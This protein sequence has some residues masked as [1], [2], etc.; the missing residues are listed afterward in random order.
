MRRRRGLEG[1]LDD[2]GGVDGYSDGGDV[3]GVEK[4]YVHGEI[5]MELGDHIGEYELG[6]YLGRGGF[7]TVYEARCLKTNRHVALKLLDKSKILKDNDL[8]QRTRREIEL[9]SGLSHPNIVEL[10][11]HFED[12]SYVYMVLELAEMGSIQQ[13]LSS[14]RHQQHNPQQW[15]TEYES[16]AYFSQVVDAVQYLHENGIVHRDISNTNVLLSSSNQVKLGDFGL[17]KQ[18]EGSDVAEPIDG[19]VLQTLCGTPNFISPEVVGQQSSSQGYPVDMF[20]L[21]C[22]LYFFLSG[23]PPFLSHG[24]DAIQATL[25]KVRELNFSIP[26]HISA[27]AADLIHKLMAKD[28]LKRL[29]LF[30]VMQ[31]PFMMTGQNSKVHSFLSNSTSTSS[32][33]GSH[34]FRS[35]QIID[36]YKHRQQQHSLSP[37]PSSSFSRFIPTT[38]TTDVPGMYVPKINDVTFDSTSFLHNTLHAPPM[39][40]QSHRYSDNPPEAEN[41]SNDV[42]PKVN[43]NKRSSTTASSAMQ[44]TVDTLNYPRIRVGSPDSSFVSTPT[45]SALRDIGGMSFQTTGWASLRDVHSHSHN[46][47]DQNI[48][49]SENFHVQYPES[50]KI[51]SASQRRRQFLSAEEP[52]NNMSKEYAQPPHNN[53]SM[54]SN[55]EKRLLKSD[56]NTLDAM[57]SSTKRRRRKKSN[58]LPKLCARRLPGMVHQWDNAHVEVKDNGDIEL[59]VHSA[60]IGNKTTSLSLTVYAGGEELSVCEG[61][62]SP[63]VMKYPNIDERYVRFYRK[64]H[65]I[66]TIIQ[67]KTPKLV[68]YDEHCK[69]MLMENTPA[70]VVVRFLKEKLDVSYVNRNEQTELSICNKDGEILFCTP[71]V[72]PGYAKEKDDAIALPATVPIEHKP[73]VQDAISYMQKCKKF[74][75]QFDNHTDD[76]LFPIRVGKRR[77]D[78]V[79]E[80]NLAT[81]LPQSQAHDGQVHFKSYN[82]HSRNMSLNTSVWGDESSSFLVTS[83]PPVQL[84]EVCGS[85]DSRVFVQLIFGIGWGVFLSNGGVMLLLFSGSRVCISANGQQIDYAL[86]DGISVSAQSSE[87]LPPQIKDALFALSAFVESVRMMKH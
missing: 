15:F 67:S 28:P 70:D 87:S 38:S 58:P 17:A 30:E 79:R 54:V 61:V 14:R 48:I 78:T 19:H 2:V 22:L 34:S 69:C 39:P 72:L 46:T 49:P 40:Y 23:K 83:P 32:T 36:M 52:K 8:I 7:A 3:S 74:N 44:S 64:L 73:L 77:N 21:G 75:S 27:T 20:S 6:R 41:Q 86:P 35:Q 66:V 71:Y 57:E 42:Y 18:I 59:K 43:F 24:S 65:K 68:M 81:S 11:K 9:H 5:G 55:S 13:H 56:R 25:R 45:Y 29:S 51:L 16:R 33:K 12:D 4:V 82:G 26:P 60:N 10:Y 63:V 1:A 62:S 50:A 85:E 37:S 53:E 80:E 84:V 47:K 31:H 76:T